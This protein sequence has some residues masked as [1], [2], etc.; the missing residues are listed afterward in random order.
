MKIVEL[1]QKNIQEL[2]GLLEEKL[3]KMAEL[4]FDLAGGKT[5]NLKE[6]REIKLA[7]ARIKTLQREVQMK[8]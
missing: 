7:I 8:I 2:A 4:K 5:K 3:A 6:I 1:R